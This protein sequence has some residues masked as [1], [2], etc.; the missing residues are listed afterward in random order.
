MYAIKQAYCVVREF[1]RQPESEQAK[2]SS[3][4]WGII[5]DLDIKLENYVGRSVS[6]AN[7]KEVIAAYLQDS[8]YFAGEC[9]AYLSILESELGKHPLF[10]QLFHGTQPGEDDV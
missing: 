4:V 3:L 2:Y 9:V 5:T 1:T 8:Y 7:S 6:A 10:N